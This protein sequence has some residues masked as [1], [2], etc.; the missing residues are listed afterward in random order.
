[1]LNPFK[2]FLSWAKSKSDRKASRSK[3]QR[4]RRA[5]G[6]SLEQRQ[7]LACDLC[8]SEFFF[9]PVN[10]DHSTDQ[11]FEVAGTP[12]VTIADNTYLVIVY[13]SVGPPGT[14]TPGVIR[15]VFDLGGLTLGSNG[16]LVVLEGGATYS[17]DPGATVIQ[18]TDAF[19]GLPDDR[20]QDIAAF[21]N[22]FSH[23]FTSNSVLL[24]S[25]SP[26]ALPVPHGDI[27]I[28]DDG[29]LDVPWTIL[30]GFG[31]PGVHAG[32]EPDDV[33]YGNI[34]FRSGGNT[35]TS[36][37]GVTVVDVKYT[38]Y[39]ARVGNS[40]GWSADE[41]MVGLA[42]R[43]T[44]GTG[45]T[46]GAYGG[47]ETYREYVGFELDHVGS[48]NFFSSIAGNKFHDHN[49][50]AVRETAERG[51]EGATVYLDINGNG[52]LDDQVTVLEPDDFAIDTNLS[53]VVPGVTLTDE[54]ATGELT[55]SEIVASEASHVATGTLAINPVGNLRLDFR[56]P[57]QS[58]RI[59]FSAFGSNKAGVLEAYN[60]EGTLL[61]SSTTGPLAT[62]FATLL[63]ER[64]SADIAYAL[65]KPEQ[66]GS[67]SAVFDN[68]Q[69]TRPEPSAVTGTVGDYSFDFIDV[70]IDGA[71]TV[72]VRTF[73][74]VDQRQT[75]PASGSHSL[76]VDQPKD[77]TERNFG[78]ES[79]R[80][81]D[82]IGRT[83]FGEWWIAGSIG[84]DFV[85]EY[86]GKWN[87]N[88]QW[89]ETI[90]AD[91]DGDGNMDVLGLIDGEMW[92]SRSN[93]A[94]FLAH[95]YWG[96]WPAASTWANV[97][98]VDVN[99]DGLQDVIARQQTGTW[100]AAISNG[101]SFD[102]EPWAH[103]P[104]N[105]IWESI[106]TGDFNGD[107]MTDL[108]GRTNGVWYVEVSTG[109]EFNTHQWG[110]WSNAVAWE[111]VRVGDFDGD[112]RDDIAGRANGS[113][114][115]ARSN[116][117][118]FENSHWGRWSTAVTWDDV[119]VADFNGDGRDDIA[120]RD[121]GQWWIAKSTS[122]F[123]LMEYWGKWSTAVT[124]HDV[125]VGDVDGDGKDDIVGRLDNGHWWTAHS[126]GT[127]FSI[128]HWGEWAA[129][130]WNNVDVGRFGDFVS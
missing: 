79:N 54:Y 7:M 83:D 107:G 125:Q 98:A 122:S 70:H 42:T 110:A 80:P 36:Q 27:D 116:G 85:A 13:G 111:D 41:W 8:I 46:I 90:V 115:I 2:S 24:V 68:L 129:T 78:V 74:E 28:N 75:T 1:M 14:S 53:N 35:A 47:N 15:T 23:V 10:G 9:N 96:D 101:T 99:G 71:M 67:T 29:I 88:V 124:W 50:N 108:A 3:L 30:D 86:F 16:H 59:D 22:S 63:I 73:D 91:V 123:F 69:F 128:E 26:D 76:V 5:L 66:S 119:L 55:G 97:A 12:G 6:E 93:G 21:S 4:K 61:D 104:N 56:E 72:P 57:V 31:L 95:E 87:G 38:G 19:A 118:A 82:I 34:T 43:N 52:T 60:A 33:P 18:G 130:N 112:G 25:T 48:P 127:Y 126:T 117:T 20:F 120:G 114:W 64:P 84:T 45:Y 65:A 37:P 106:L 77:F 102:F 89:E 105:V 58:V 94:S 81:F 92:V 109:T 44:T 17:V 113:W 39:V 62:V 100:W 49:G 40:K 11:Y 103:R 51:I 32:G 121:N